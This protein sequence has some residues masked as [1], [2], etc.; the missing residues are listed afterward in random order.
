MLNHLIPKKIHLD[1]QDYSQYVT[2]VSRLINHHTMTV[3]GGAEPPPHTITSPDLQFY[4]SEQWLL[5][6]A[7]LTSDAA[8]QEWCYVPD[9]NVWLCVHDTDDDNK[10]DDDN[11]E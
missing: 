5:P 4:Y 2:L 6:G 9:K 3:Y 8:S 1:I 10:Y 7:W 11:D